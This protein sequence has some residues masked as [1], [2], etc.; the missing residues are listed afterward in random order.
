[1]TLPR[2]LRIAA[3]QNKS[4]RSH[5]FG[6]RGYY[7]GGITKSGL[8]HRFRKS[9]PCGSYLTVK[10]TGLYDMTDFVHLHVHSEY[11]CDGACRIKSLVARKEWGSAVAITDH[12]VMFGVLIFIREAGAKA[13][14]SAAIY[15]A[16]RA[17]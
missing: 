12:G 10:R 13:L 5:A 16:P 7:R 9:L 2:G 3:E 1:M 11:S 4:P 6:A 8:N 15:V 17:V 14:L